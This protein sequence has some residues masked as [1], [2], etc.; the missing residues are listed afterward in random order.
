MDRRTEMK[1][2]AA[3]EIFRDVETL[4]RVAAITVP[5][6]ELEKKLVQASRSRA[7]SSPKRVRGGAGAPPRMDHW[8]CENA[9]SILSPALPGCLTTFALSRL[10][11]SPT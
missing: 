1:I 6:T 11:A 5:I 4:R 9:A 7:A 8:T 3:T 2:L 10:P